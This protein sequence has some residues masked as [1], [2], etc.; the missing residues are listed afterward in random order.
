MGWV[1]LFLCWVSNYHALIY[2]SIL[3]APMHYLW[4]NAVFYLWDKSEDRVNVCEA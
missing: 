4:V 2:S 3:L 1:T